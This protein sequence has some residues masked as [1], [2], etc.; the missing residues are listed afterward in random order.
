MAQ[1]LKLDVRFL[2][3]RG[4]KKVQVRRELGSA[5]AAMSDRLSRAVAFKAVQPRR[6][7]RSKVR[8]TARTML[9]VL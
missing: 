7:K 4:L 1:S 8:V 2:G 5:M 3:P 6:M 9:N